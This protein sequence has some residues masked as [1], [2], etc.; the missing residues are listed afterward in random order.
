MTITKRINLLAIIMLLAGNILSGQ[1]F[2]KLPHGIKTTSGDRSVEIRFYS[3]SIVRV[4]RFIKGQLS[5]TPSLSVIKTP[6]TLSLKEG[7]D[8]KNVTVNSGTL[9]VSIDKATGRVRFLSPDGRVLLSEKESGFGAIPK[10]TCA[11]PAYAIS[12]SFQLRDNEA[13]YGLGQHQ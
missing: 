1:G 9:K 2:E 11:M 12:Q 7:S 6:E 13:I 10:G 8:E 4:T 3:S 5:E